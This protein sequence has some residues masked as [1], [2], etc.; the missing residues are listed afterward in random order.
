VKTIK[1]YFAYKLGEDLFIGDVLESKIP[2]LKY[3]SFD[4]FTHPCN[5]FYFVFTI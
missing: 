4:F 5:A 1:I 3:V 2:I